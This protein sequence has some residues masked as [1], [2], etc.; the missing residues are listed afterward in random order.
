[1]V[2]TLPLQVQ[3]S[4]RMDLGLDIDARR[5]ITNVNAVG[6]GSAVD[7]NSLVIKNNII[8]NVAQRG[9]SLAGT[10]P[11][12]TGNKVDSNYIRN[13]GADLANGGYGVLLLTNAYADVSN[14]IVNVNDDAIGIQLQNFY[15]NGTMTWNNNNVTVGQDAFGIHANLFYA[16]AGVLNINNNTVNA[17]AG[18]TGASDYTWGINVWSVQVG[19]TVNVTNNTVGSAGGEFAR[20]INLWN[21][22]TSNTV[23]VTGGS[24]ARSLTGINLDNVDIFFGAGANTMA[25]VTNTSVTATAGQTGIRARSNTV[26]AVAPAGSV[27]LNLTGVNVSATGTATGIA[28]DA[29]SASLT[30]TATV[31]FNGSSNL[32]GGSNTPV[33]INGDQSQFYAGTG[34]INA[35]AAGSN[36]AIQ[37]SS[38]TAANARENLVIAGGTTVNMGANTAARAF[39]SPQYS[40][41]EVAGSWTVPSRIAGGLHPAYIDGRMKFTNG[42]LST[43]AV[44]DTIEFGNTAADI[45][46]GA[47]PEN[48]DSHIIGRVKMLS[49]AVGNAAIDMLGAKLD[50][51]AGPGAD[52][53]NLVITRATYAS[54]P[55]TPAFPANQSIRTV[56]N[57]QPSNPTASRASVQYRYLNTAANI[58]GQNPASIYAYRNT[59]GTWQKISASLTSAL[60]GDVYT[61]APFNAPGFSPWTLSSQATAIQPDFTPLIDIDGNGLAT[62]GSSRDFIVNVQEVAGGTS[63]GQIIVRIT[64]SSNFAITYPTT[65]GTSNVFGGTPNNN[66]DWT[67]TEDVNFIYATLNIGQTITPFNYSSIGYTITRNAGVA[68]NTTFNINARII[69]GTGGD[70]NA[71]NNSTNQIIVAQ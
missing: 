19:S 14:N 41:V 38:I 50:A 42:I 9:V 33:S 63:A 57:I 35:P 29:P 47:S 34:T 21:N 44:T 66:G 31:Y 30:N 54:G 46:T 62:T 6:G 23:T 51:Q 40:I 16:P 28:V 27:T 22:P 43:N 12:L 48:D 10:G 64:K 18:V 49:R 55:I 5:G 32:T 45:L 1:M 26:N 25:A 65:S 13:F 53:G 8:Q 37:F 69:T 68:T 20:G 58:N 39:A 59:A 52:V 56:W 4:C 3:A 60:V 11:A 71:G 67:F 2:T 70:S 17:R 61:T 36:N 15:Q 24:V 7:V